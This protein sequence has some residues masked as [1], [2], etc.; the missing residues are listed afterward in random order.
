MHVVSNTTPLI[1]FA[2]IN[3]LDIL[4]ALFREL[5][6]PPQVIDELADK[7]ERFPAIAQLKDVPFI[8]RHSPHNQLLLQTLQRDLD[9]GEAAAIIVAIEQNADLILLDEI[10]GR[11]M[12]TFYGLRVLGSIGC[13][14]EAKRREIIPTVQPLLAAMQTDARF[15]VSRK[16]YHTV[17]QTVGEA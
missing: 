15:W 3:R 5:S 17:L 2:A 6:V 12:A 1:N 16:L 13:L 7:Q 14:I 11:E 9:A 10:A 4:T 8:H